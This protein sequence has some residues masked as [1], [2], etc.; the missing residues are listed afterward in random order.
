MNFNSQTFNLIISTLTIFMKIFQPEWFY[1]FKILIIKFKRPSK[2]K[3]YKLIINK[4]LIKKK[5][6]KKKKKKTD[7]KVEI[8]NKHNVIFRGFA[9]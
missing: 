1:Y 5:K 8:I 9:A 2:K 4:N 6:I 3:T 7:G